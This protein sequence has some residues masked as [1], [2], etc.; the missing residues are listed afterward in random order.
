MPLVGMAH[1]AELLDSLQQPVPTVS[2]I[3]EPAFVPLSVTFS[4][5][6]HGAIVTSFASPTAAA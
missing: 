2:A 1:A 4:A 6:P 3:A 5:R